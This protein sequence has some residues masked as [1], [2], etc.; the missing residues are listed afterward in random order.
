MPFAS[1]SRLVQI[2]RR[3]C[4][5]FVVL[6]KDKSEPHDEGTVQ[7]LPVALEGP[8]TQFPDP[9]SQTRKQ[10]L[11]FSALTWQDFERLCVRLVRKEADVEFCR[12]YGKPGQQQEGIDLFSRKRQATR[13]QVYQCKRVEEFGRSEVKEALEKFLN[14]SWAGRAERFTLCVKASLQ[15]TEC[16]EEIE[17]QRT[18]LAEEGIVLDAW[19]AEELS[20]KLKDDGETVDD[21]F[22]QAWTEAFCSSAGTATL[23]KNR[24]DGR[25]LADYRSRLAQFYRHVFQTHDP[26]MPFD[27]TGRDNV[28]QLKDRYVLPD[29]FDEIVSL[30]MAIVQAVQV[31][32]A[33]PQDRANE[34]RRT[35]AGD[36]SGSRSYRQRRSL[37]EWLASARS[38]VVLGGPGSGKSTLLRFIALDLLGSEPRLAKFN[39]SHK[40]YLPVWISVPYWTSVLARQEVSANS[41]SR[42]VHTWLNY[43]NEEGLWPVFEQALDDKRLLL[44]VD[45]LDE[46]SAEAPAQV[47]VSILQVFAAQRECP[48]IAVGRPAGFER[49]SMQRVGWWVGELAEFTLDQQRIVELRRRDGLVTLVAKFY[50]DDP[51]FRDRILSRI[52]PLPGCLRSVI[53]EFFSDGSGALPDALPTLRQYDDDH[54]PELKTQ[55]AI[56]Y[57]RALVSSNLPVDQDVERLTADIVCYGP[58]HDERRQAAFCGLEVLGRLDIM[59]QAEERIGTE[60]MPKSGYLADYLRTSFLYAIYYRDG[61]K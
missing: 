2:H 30:G 5:I 36:T 10:E 31:E 49:L 8:P 58:D 4:S 51:E 50:G 26:G 13:Y 7:K 60:R 11:P 14:G 56:A 29:V 6:A 38:V 9:P 17:R 48:V 27:V 20:R 39:S 19:D 16:Q 61:R 33:V 24:I 59:L 41:L 54:S 34:T 15:R 55:R 3:S 12:V 22:G 44:L 23:N 45:G 21:F 42:V 46:Y 1:E 40:P 18:I 52:T 28:L 53:I 32:E 43:W 47:A 35:A 25:R 37:D 57:Y